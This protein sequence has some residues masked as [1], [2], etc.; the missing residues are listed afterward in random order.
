MKRQ[1]DFGAVLDAHLV[2]DLLRAAI[3]LPDKPEAMRVETRHRTEFGVR[4]YPSGHL[5]RGP[6]PP[7]YVGLRAA[8]PARNRAR[9]CAP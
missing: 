3:R 2:V 4:F 9:D 7:T 5:H 6:P 1:S 8:P